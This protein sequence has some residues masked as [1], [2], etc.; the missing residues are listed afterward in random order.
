LPVPGNPEENLLVKA[1]LMMQKEF[2]LPEVHFHLHKVIPLG[3]G[4]GGGS[5]DAAFAIRLINHHFTLGLSDER[6]TQT[7]K[8][9]RC[10]QRQSAKPSNGKSTS[11]TSRAKFLPSYQERQKQKSLKT[12]I[13]PVNKNGAFSIP[14]PIFSATAT[15]ILQKENKSRRKRLQR[16]SRF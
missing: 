2:G 9:T 1:W 4:L 6:P 11:Q 5:A 8:P 15:L 7:L 14:K 10:P 16:Q 12:K 3:A 13:I